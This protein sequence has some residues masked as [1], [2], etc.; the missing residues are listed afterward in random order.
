MDPSV[1]PGT[2]VKLDQTSVELEEGDSVTLKATVSPENATDKTVTWTSSDESIATVDE[3]GKVT[4]VK[5]G[6]V[7]ITATSGIQSATCS[8]TVKER[9]H[10]RYE[11]HVRSNERDA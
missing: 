3:N 1:I 7:T 10:S 4:A 2:E 6:N 11:S 5:A 8:V 9:V